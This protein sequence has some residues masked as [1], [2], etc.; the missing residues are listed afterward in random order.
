[1]EDA[2]LR[3]VSAR[4]R[5][6]TIPRGG[7]AA[8]E[9]RRRA[10]LPAQITLETALY[11]LVLLAAIATRFWDLGSRALHHDE[12]LHTYYS[13][14][15]AEGGGY[16]HHPLMHG[17]SLFH[18]NALAYLLFGATDYVSRVA[19]ALTGVLLVM[20]PWLLRGRRL[21][22]RWGALIASTLILLSP[23][24]LYYSRFIRHDIYALI[25]TFS[26]FIAL[27]RYVDRPE[28]RWVILGG[29]SAG[30]L[31]TTHEV[32]FVVL[33]IFVTF[34]ALAVTLRSAPALLGV[35]GGAI[36]AFGVVAAALAR[37]GMPPLPGI[38]WEN[39]TEAQVVRYLLD[40]LIHPLV[41][42]ALGIL[43]LAA[44]ASLWVLDRRRDVA[45]G[46]WVDGVLGD[47]PPGSMS[48]GL[49]GLA[50]ERRGLAIGA[51]AGA[52]L[53][54]ALYTSLF[55]NMMGLA[56]GTFGALG[57]WLAQHNVQRGEQPWF[58]YLLLLPQYEFVGVLLAP[59]A[60][61][62]TAWRALR[63]WRRG[64]DVELSDRFMLRAFLIYWAAVM[65]AVLSWAGE[66]MPWLTVHIALPLALLAAS[67]LGEAAEAVDAGWRRWRPRARRAGALFALAVP[68][69]LAAGFLLMA[70]A[71]D[72]PY[73]TDARGQLARA[74]RPEAARHWWVVYLPAVAL[75]AL[76]VVGVARL[77]ARRA[78]PLLALSVAASLLLAQVHASWRMTYREGDV[79]KDMLIYV[80]SSP[81][82]VRLARQLETL[83]HDLTGGMG[84]EVWY[85]SD[86]QWPFNW[87]LRDFPNRR[88][89]GS[90]LP[91]TPDA[92]I[93]L[94]SVDHA[95]ADVEQQ[96]SKDYT[97]Q[98]YPMRWWFPEEDTY[99]RF[100]IAP[101]LKTEWRQNYQTQQKP[102]YTLWDVARSVGSSLWAMRVPQEQGKIFRIVAYRD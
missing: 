40:L 54:V 78:A 69:L 74:V 33:F 101:E 4:D 102:P 81:D 64:G 58:Y 11:G 35:A 5:S 83:S 99:R 12:S 2:Q 84:L 57:Y 100:A 71:S 65:F 55:T 31:F 79:P 43:I 62:W 10:L 24:I 22:G 73:V 30:F 82:V 44:I 1:M 93:I 34:T 80:Q 68:L 17:P 46:G 86:T 87:Y 66:K 9:A 48:A 77:G 89:F 61:V 70:W 13:W 41:V 8:R 60:T 39:P 28:R 14:V 19:P 67:L 98:E 72:G 25:G 90:T 38:P 23:S 56:S 37:L 15:Y 94:L 95:T 26:L 51:A 53:F 52:L 36:V 63:V 7:Q 96:L 75:V 16:V 47:A 85:D 59:I 97:Y 42:A 45:A 32:S 6:V 27:V 3:T 18:L 21:L 92:P 76:V 91:G 29:V 20:M 49:R 50:H 88:L